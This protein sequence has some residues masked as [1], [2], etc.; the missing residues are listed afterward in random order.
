MWN[1]IRAI[2]KD[3]IYVE[4]CKFRLYSKYNGKSL[5]DLSR[6]M[7]NVWFIFKRD[8]PWPVFSVVRVSTWH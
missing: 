7:I 8:Q 3:Q 6:R 5:E 4:P 2:S 1:G